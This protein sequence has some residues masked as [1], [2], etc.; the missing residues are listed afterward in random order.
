MFSRF[1]RRDVL[2]ALG[3]S[4]AFAA[5]LRGLPGPPVNLGILAG[6][7]AR[8][9]K[10]EGSGL[11]SLYPF[12][13]HQQQKTRRRLA[14]LNQLPKD[15][16][17]WKAEARARVLACLSYRP[18][19]CEPRAQVLERVDRGDYIRER[20]T[21]HTT[22]DIEVPAFVLIPKRTK[23]PAPGVVA[24]HD[25]G[26]F[27][28]YGKEKI[29]ETENEHPILTQYRR[30]YYGGQSF[31]VALARRGY[32]VIAID[33]FYFGDRR[34]IL[35]EDLAQGIND[36]SKPETQ[37]V[38]EKINGR[39]GGAEAYVLRDILSAGFTWAG[40]MIWDDL[41]TVDYLITRQEVDP[42]RLACTGLSIGGYRTNFLAGLDRRI[43]A[44]C[45]AGWMTSLR[46][47]FPGQEKHTMPS[48]TVPGLLDDLDY[49]DVGSLTMPNALMVVHGWEDEL[50]PPDGV[51]AAFDN[52]T[53]CYQAI[54]KPE[55]FQTFTFDGPHSFPLA[56]QQKM[57]EW[58]DRWV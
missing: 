41:R 39:N 14:Y 57:M 48:S 36:H 17:A 24:L 18:E 2:R 6:R 33:M 58:F 19:S 23:F 16:E 27:Y 5:G 51:R 45:V 56:A 53:R 30:D 4:G 26:G 34:L 29:V 22:P 20:V 54:G 42:T 47:L 15:L 32:V 52:L 38:I 50:F 31:P 28:Y 49:P 9:E 25:H 44:A 21:F 3:A 13:K 46:Y 10:W 37:E 8:G 35:D 11:G 43:K 1:T 12:I 40:V 55:R 7:D